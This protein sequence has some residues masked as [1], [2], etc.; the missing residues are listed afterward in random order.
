MFNFKFQRS[1]LSSLKINIQ[2]SWESYKPNTGCRCSHHFRPFTGRG[3]LI[4]NQATPP[5]WCWCLWVGCAHFLG[6]ASHVLSCTSHRGSQ[7]NK[8][9]ELLPWILFDNFFLLSTK[10]NPSPKFF[11]YSAPQIRFSSLLIWMTPGCS[12][13]WPYNQP[14]TPDHGLQCPLWQLSV[15]T[16]SSSP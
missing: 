14:P 7:L 8:D 5:K 12:F 16:L 13:P 10:D 4:L 2:L 3:T 6:E 11:L 9:V 1:F 15:L